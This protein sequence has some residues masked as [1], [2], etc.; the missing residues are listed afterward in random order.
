[1]REYLGL[2]YIDRN[3]SRAAGDKVHIF[4]VDDLGLLDQLVNYK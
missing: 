1:M 2:T 4:V 3:V